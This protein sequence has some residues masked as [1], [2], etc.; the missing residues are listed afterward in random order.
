MKWLA[1][2]LGK[3]AELREPVEDQILG[4]VAWDPTA[5]VWVFPPHGARS[6]AI[7][8]VGGLAPDSRLFPFA[9]E[10][11]SNALA[12]QHTVSLAL[13]SEAARTPRSAEIIRA[14]QLEVVDLSWPERPRDGMVYFRGAEQ[15]P[16]WRFDLIDGQPVNLGCDT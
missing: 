8:L 10:L 11:H 9:R 5:E 12:F 3:P 6:F 2:L 15:G 13:E 7:A 1:R 14:L 4:L 16:V